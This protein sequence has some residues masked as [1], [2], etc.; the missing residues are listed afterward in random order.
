MSPSPD[1]HQVLGVRVGASPDDIDRAWKQRLLE[2]HPDR[3]PDASP[4]ERSRLDARTR[5]V[6]AAHDALGAAIG[7]ADQRVDQ[8]AELCRQC[9]ATPTATFEFTV[10]VRR[11]RRTAAGAYC[12]DCALHHGRRAQRITLMAFWF[13]GLPIGVLVSN[14]KG[15][16]RAALLKESHGGDARALIPG[17]SA[18]AS[19]G[20]LVFIAAPVLLV[21][22]FTRV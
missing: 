18:M 7:A 22:F 17:P 3:H 2:V 1:P 16:W 20:F 4:A 13:V 14:A 10:P 21:L 9:G 12:R 8:A 11:F 15:L 19:W 6:N 5:E